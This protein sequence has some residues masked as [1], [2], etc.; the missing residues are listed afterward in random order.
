LA[1]N[2]EADLRRSP[3][4]IAVPFEIGRFEPSNETQSTLAGR[5]TLNL[6]IRPSRAFGT[7]DFPGKTPNLH[8]GK[9]IAYSVNN[10]FLP[11]QAKHKTS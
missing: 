8:S 7:K 2:V 10:S 11:R 5:R 3:V 6:P 9:K 4:K 1:R